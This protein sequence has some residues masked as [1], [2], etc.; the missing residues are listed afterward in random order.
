VAEQFTVVEPTGKVEPE[1]GLQLTGMDPSRS[2]VA[3]AE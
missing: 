3:E 1:A 2:S